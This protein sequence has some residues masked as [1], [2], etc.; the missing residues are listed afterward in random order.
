LEKDLE[1]E[2][3]NG[4]ELAAEIKKLQRQLFEAKKSSEEEHRRVVEYKETVSTLEQRI[5]TLKRQLQD[6]VRTPGSRVP[7]FILR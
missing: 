4:R 6:S 3:R 2:K 7:L 1:L 5:T